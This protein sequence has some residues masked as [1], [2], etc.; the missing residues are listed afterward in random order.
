M[1]C[2]RMSSAVA[3]PVSR[4]VVDGNR[5]ILTILLETNVYGFNTHERTVNTP[6]ELVGPS[7]GGLSTVCSTR[8]R[9]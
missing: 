3:K 6:A 5:P 8:K 7:A 2:A 9:S 4:S 1:L